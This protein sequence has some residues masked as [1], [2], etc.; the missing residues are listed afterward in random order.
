MLAATTLGWR[1]SSLV[2]SMIAMVAVLP[3]LV[4]LAVDYA[5]QFHA[6]ADRAMQDETAVKL[7]RAAEIDGQVGETFRRQLDVDLVEQA[8]QIHVNRAIDDDPQGPVL[9][10]FTNV[11]QGIREIRVFQRRHGDEEVV[12]QVDVVHD[13]NFNRRE[14]TNQP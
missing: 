11:H 5:I 13:W 2:L 10:V 9:I 6:R 3:V 7:D 12:G 4:G 1:A 8:S 14:G